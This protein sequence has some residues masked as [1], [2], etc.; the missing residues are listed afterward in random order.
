MIGE[1]RG[2][3]EEKISKSS[4]AVSPLLKSLLHLT[5]EAGELSWSCGFKFVEL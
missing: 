3:K 4:G 1:E 5:S 2:K